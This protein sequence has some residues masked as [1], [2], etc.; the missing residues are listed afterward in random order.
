[1]IVIFLLT[2]ILFSGFFAG[3]ETGLLVADRILLQ[4]DSRKGRVSSRAAEYLLN[5]PE[6]L[7]GT[8]LIGF[9]IANISSGVL[10]TSYM[11]NIGYGGYTWIAI[12]AMTFLFLIFD[13]IIPK[14]FFRQ[15]ANTAAVTLAPLLLAF[16]FLFL[17]VSILLN[18]IVK[19]I[20]FLT[21]Q[22]D[23]EREELKSRRDLRFLVNHAGGEMGLTID[24]QRI[25]EDILD[26]RDQFAREVMVPFHKLPVVNINQNPL[27]AVKLGLE[28]GYRFIPVSK[29]RTDNMLGYLD[30]YDMFWNQKG[31]IPELLKKAVF[32]PETRRIPDLLLD[33]NR[34][35]QEVAFLADEYGGVAGMITPS[36]I[37][38]D[39][40]HYIPEEGSQED[41]IEKTG[42]GIF[43]VAGEADLE[44]LCRELGIGLSSS[45][46][47]TI[48]G[49]LCER[50]G[51]I[52]EKDAVYK[53]SGYNF[54]VTDRDDKHI[55][56][57]E[58][59]KTE[60]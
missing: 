37:I 20:L 55:I 43:K 25:I 10:V 13:E 2:C 16:Y 4:S 24:D 9:N 38:G 56:S 12:L 27:D 36:Q 18:A 49:Y 58:I 23:S 30:T 3:I 45:Y 42:E 41:F 5:K 54:K 46:N 1:M 32:Y 15:N 60:G 44:D 35:K 29:E 47:K 14:S 17:P 28:S 19:I 8:T 34:G 21:G 26:F 57:L 48:G 22:K 31:T 11:Y 51:I 7:L 39:I 52:P 50:M 6:R 53:E 40:M 33:M 59:R